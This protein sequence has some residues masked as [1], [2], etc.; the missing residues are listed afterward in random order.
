MDA[1]IVTMYMYMF[2]VKCLRMPI[3][4]EMLGNACTIIGKYGLYGLHL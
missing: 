4:F 3:I 1:E 2:N